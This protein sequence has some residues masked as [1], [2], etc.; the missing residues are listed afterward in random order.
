M[1]KYMHRLPGIEDPTMA[2]GTTA[3]SVALARGRCDLIEEFLRLGRKRDLELA[4]YASL[5]PRINAEVKQV[6]EEA[7]GRTTDEG[8]QT[9]LSQE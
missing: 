2:D 9:A 6:L 5:E 1:I 3:F 4:R 7:I 8:P